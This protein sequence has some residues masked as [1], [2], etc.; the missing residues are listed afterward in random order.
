MEKAT[1]SIN[2]RHYIKPKRYKKRVVAKEKSRGHAVTE[3]EYRVQ[4]L[5]ERPAHDSVT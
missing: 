2:R 5:K 3:K 1:V 4:G